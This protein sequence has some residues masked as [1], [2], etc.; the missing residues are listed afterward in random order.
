M[1]YAMVEMSHYRLHIMK[2]T[3]LISLALMLG[4][5][6]AG[7]RAEAH[8]AFGISINL[9]GPA[10]FS[11]PPAVYYAPPPVLYHPVPVYHAPHA[12]YGGPDRWQKRGHTRHRG[13]DHHGRHR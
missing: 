9:G 6:A 10:F 7:G 3:Y 11:S 1:Q 13:H 5:G 12:Y 2:K 4:L 8:D